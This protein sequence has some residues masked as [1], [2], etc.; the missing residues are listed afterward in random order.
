MLTRHSLKSFWSCFAALLVVGPVEHLSD[1][2]ADDSSSLGSDAEVKVVRGRVVDEQDLPV[3][4]ARLWLPLRYQPRRVAETI[5]DESGRFELRFP[6]DWVSPRTNGSSWTIWAY[7]PGHGIATESPFQ[8]VRGNSQQEVDLKLAPQSPLAEALVQPQN[9]QTKVGY[10]LVPDEM[11]SCVSART[12]ADGVAALPALRLKPLFRVQIVSE[13]FGTQAIRVDRDIEQ[14]VRDI[15]LRETA[16]I[17]GR[18]IGERAEWLRG[19][20]LVFTVDNQDEWTQT[21]GEAKVVTDENGRF[22]VPVIA[23]GGPLHT[24]VRLDPA[25]PVRPRLN[26]KRF[27][28]A[29]ETLKLEIPLV[30]APTVHGKVQAKSSGNPIANAEISLGYGGYHQSDQVT[31]DQEGRYEGRVLPGPVRVHIIALPEGYVQLGAPWAE[32]YQVPSD[33]EEYELPNIDVVGTHKLSGRLIDDKGQPLPR[34]RLTAVDKNRRYGFALTDAEGRFSMNVPDGVETRIEA[35]TDQRG[36]EPVEVVEREPLLVRFTGNANEKAMEAVRDLK[37]DVALTGRVLFGEKPLAG[38]RLILSRGI[39]VELPI[40]P[41]V[42]APARRATGMRMKKV[43][44]TVSDV[45]GTYRLSGLK[46]GESYA[47]EVQPSF[48]ATDPAWQHQSPWAPRLPDSSQGDVTLPDISLRRLSQSLAG[49]VVDPDGKPVA[50]AQVSAMLCNGQSLARNSMA[51]APP[52]T[53]TDSEG[54]F[55]LQELPDE[56]LALMAYMRTKEG[57]PIRFFAKVNPE[58]NQHDVRIVLDP[59]LEDEEKK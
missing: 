36:Q 30:P 57:G 23:S 7:A 1:I 49:K 41:G 8:V 45:N 25:L 51:G 43:A 22:E 2:G 35:F 40:P 56:P 9:Y 38:V 46:A 31:T 19:V 44:S 24:Y 12:N 47:I 42:N 52:W 58:L 33:V 32:P 54:G 39:P 26:D 17:E 15:R 18:L 16:R 53:E 37:P 55:K 11:L 6:T 48:A 59:S 20:P 28:T 29:G 5:A 50:G 34:M 27:L 13:E 14:A 4:G 10:D 21:S 3:A